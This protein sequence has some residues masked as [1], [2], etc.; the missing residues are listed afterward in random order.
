METMFNAD[1]VARHQ[2][3]WDEGCFACSQSVKQQVVNAVIDGKIY[4]AGCD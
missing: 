1:V 2:K 4:L 3:L